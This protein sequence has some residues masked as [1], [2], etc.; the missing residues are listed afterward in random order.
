MKAT[1]ILLILLFIFT[2]CK[3]VKKDINQ[4]KEIS[5]V[6]PP[7][8]EVDTNLKFIDSCISSIYLSSSKG[9][10]EKYGNIHEK[11]TVRPNFLPQVGIK[12]STSKEYLILSAWPGSGKNEF[13]Y[14]K[15]GFLPSDEINFI[16]TIESDNLNFLSC[17]GI[18]LGMSITEL[19]AIFGKKYNKIN[20]ESIST[21]VFE[22]PDYLYQSK[23]SFIDNKLFEFEFGYL[24][25]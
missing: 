10:V 15:V 19:E 2:S 1:T 11:L 21:L 20:N 24:Y 8:E 16:N 12:S 14:I 6:N 13:K 18:K 5:Q 17:K 22:L 25:P 7:I 3:S 9:I 23:Y 4:T